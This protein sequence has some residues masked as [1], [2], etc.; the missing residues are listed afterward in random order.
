MTH[1]ARDHHAAGASRYLDRFVRST[2]GSRL[3]GLRIFPN[4]K[5]VTESYAARAAALRY[6]DTFRPDDR[7]IH[8]ISV[9]DGSTPRTA[10]TFAL[11]SAWQ[12][13]S[14]DPA[15]R[16]NRG[17]AG[18]WH[19]IPRLQLHPARIEECHFTAR[20]VVIAAVHSHASM[21]ATL[22][23]VTAEEV[24]LVAMPCCV[25]IDLRE[26]PVEVFADMHVLSP[27]RTIHIWHQERAGRTESSF[28]YCRR[29]RRSVHIIS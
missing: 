20:R 19:D 1:V 4:A 13:H 29:F 8:F 25:P 16:L 24:L 26:P 12:C 5:E 10:A 6:R 3:A 2:A 23:C 22:A 14:V 17:G 15:L 9:G 21:A 28:G 7:E 18:R 11:G 27:H